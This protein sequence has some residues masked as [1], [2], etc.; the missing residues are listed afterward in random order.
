MI[1][2][3]FTFRDSATQTTDQFLR[4]V[5]TNLCSKRSDTPREL[6]EAYTAANDGQL[7]PSTASLMAMLNAA[8]EGFE[9]IY[10]FLD[11]LDE[12]PMFS[13]GQERERNELLEAINEICSWQKVCLHLFATSRKEIDIEEFFEEL[14]AAQDNFQALSVQGSHVEE[15]INKYIQHELSSRKFKSWTLELKQEVGQ[16][17]R[18]RADG[19]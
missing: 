11:A 12:C 7:S 10:I 1:Y 14:S 4:S 15:D 19:M 18:Y 9:D 5:I 13:Q 3:Y 6:Q 8:M 17:L 2:W 16:K